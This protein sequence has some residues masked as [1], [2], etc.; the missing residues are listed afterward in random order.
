MLPT[1]PRPPLQWLETTACYLTRQVN[2]KMPETF[3]NATHMWRFPTNLNK[4]SSQQLRS[5]C[6][7]YAARRERL[8]HTP[9]CFEMSPVS[10]EL[11]WDL[12]L[13]IWWYYVWVVETQ[14][15]VDP[16]ALA[17]TWV[18]VLKCGSDVALA[19]SDAAIWIMRYVTGND[20]PWKEQPITNVGIF[21]KHIS[22]FTANISLKI[23]III[24]SK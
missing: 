7:T 18:I 8:P 17:M 5:E 12:W 6:N 22:H 24:I 23:E 4:F 21:V 19:D 11:A 2:I 20:L 1:F 3:E 13:S 15:P 10:L 16:V 9:D 14:C